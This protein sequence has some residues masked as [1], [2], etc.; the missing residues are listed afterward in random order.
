MQLL[1]KTNILLML[2][3]CGKIGHLVGQFNS[4]TSLVQIIEQHIIQ[5]LKYRNLDFKSQLIIIDRLLPHL[6]QCSQPCR[7]SRPIH[8]YAWQ[9]RRF[10]NLRLLKIQQKLTK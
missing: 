2:I 1:Q 4:N 9:I 7:F 6:R 8:H 10:G 3:R 5:I